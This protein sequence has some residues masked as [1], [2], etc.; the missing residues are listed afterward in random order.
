MPETPQRPTPSNEDLPVG[1]LLST[2]GGP[3]NPSE[4]QTPTSTDAE[5]RLATLAAR[6]AGTEQMASTLAEN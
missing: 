6:M 1:T 3:S 5:G 2:V 4:S